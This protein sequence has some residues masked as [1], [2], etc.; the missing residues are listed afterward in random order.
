MNAEEMIEYVLSKGEGSER[1]RLDQALRAIPSKTARVEHLRLSIHLLLDDGSPYDEPAGLARRTIGFVARN[2]SAAH[3]PCSSK[4]RCAFR[5]VG[6]TSQSP[7]ASSSRACSR[8]CRRSSA[9]VS[10]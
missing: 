8:F 1:D 5:F 7:P 10:V 4:C 9:L 3:A 6:L 2:R